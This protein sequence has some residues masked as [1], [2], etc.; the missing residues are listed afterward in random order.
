ME[1]NYKKYLWFI[2]ISPVSLTIVNINCSLRAA[3]GQTASS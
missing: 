3:E 2:F 1:S